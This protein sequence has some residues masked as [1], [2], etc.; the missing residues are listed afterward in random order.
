MCSAVE[1]ADRGVEVVEAGVRHPG[2][3]LGADAERREGLVDDQQPPGLARPNA[4]I[5]SKSS[6]ATVRGSISSTEIPSAPARSAGLLGVVDHQRQGDDRDV[7][8]LADDGRPAELDLVILLRN[9]PLDAQDLA[10]LEEEHGVA[11]SAA[12]LEQALGVV[13]RRGDDHAQAREMGEHRIVVARVMRGRRV[14]D[15]DAAPQAG[16]AS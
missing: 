7:R 11:R 12:P 4:W 6:G 13:G 14:A 1:P 10:V 16:R 2:R 8:P 15:A 5:V 9:R 3:D